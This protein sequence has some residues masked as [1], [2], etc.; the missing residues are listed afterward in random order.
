VAVQL[1]PGKYFGEMEFFHDRRSRASIRAC[2][3]CPVDV[4]AL[5]YESLSS[6]LNESESTREALHQAADR[7]ETENV[8]FREV[9]E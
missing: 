5:D 3:T 9:K 6:I 8:Q 7:H 2:P 4:L 1:G